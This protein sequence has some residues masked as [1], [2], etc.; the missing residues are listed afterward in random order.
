M[1]TTPKQ[2]GTP[3]RRDAAATRQDLLDAA[4]DLF[5][6]SGFEGTSLRDIGERAGVDASLIARYFG[7]KVDLYI[8]ALEADRLDSDLTTE[9]VS[10][11]GIARRIVT[12]VDQHGLGPLM[13]AILQPETNPAIRLRAL[14]YLKTY[15]V[16]PLTERARERGLPNPELRA[17]MAI[18]ALTGIVH[19]RAG[20]DLPAIAAASPGDVIAGVLAAFDPDRSGR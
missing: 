2:P 20:R 12:K 5:G 3:R 8:A 9:N 6:A 7:N 14:E 11:E 13:R 16:G 18:A 4:R 10:L 19:M 17:E 1:V 15:L